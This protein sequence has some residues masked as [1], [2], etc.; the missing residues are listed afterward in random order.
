MKQR[1]D[2]DHG[3]PGSEGAFD[4]GTMGWVPNVG[5]MAQ[6]AEEYGSQDK[7]FEMAGEGKV[8]VID[9]AGKVEEGISNYP[10]P[11]NPAF[12]YGR[13]ETERRAEPRL[14]L[15]VLQADETIEN[16]FRRII[17]SHATLHVSR[18]PSGRE[19]TTDSLS[20]MENQ[21]YFSKLSHRDMSSF[22]E[23]EFVDKQGKTILKPIQGDNIQSPIW[24]NNIIQYFI[25]QSEGHSGLV[26]NNGKIHIP[27]I[28]S[29][30]YFYDKENIGSFNLGK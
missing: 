4:A 8:R 1:W 13:P 15:I 17:P 27:S 20:E 30:L 6:K 26:E 9:A 22:F 21:R 11:R 7:T 10:F 14:G 5:L 24:K 29:K 28:Y 25:F 23:V 3:H 2:G 12:E 19:V 18:V 16:E